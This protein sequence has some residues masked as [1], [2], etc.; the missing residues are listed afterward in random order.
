MMMKNTRMFCSFFF[1]MIF[2]LLGLDGWKGFG[3]LSFS[4]L[5]SFFSFVFVFV[6][7]FFFS[8]LVFVLCFSVS[9]R[10]FLLY[11]HILSTSNPPHS[12]FKSFS[13]PQQ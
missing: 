10:P 12:L 7:V 2:F 8:V 3:F 9:V 11:F 5:F 4:F 13:H 1:E 6:F